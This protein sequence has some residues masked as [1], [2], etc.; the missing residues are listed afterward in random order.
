[1]SLPLKLSVT[2]IAFSGVFVIAFEGGKRR[3][4]FCVLDPG[5]IQQRQDGAKA[6]GALNIKG[7]GARLLTGAVV[8]SEVGQS[9]KHVLKNV[10]KVEKFVLDVVRNSLENELVFPFVFLL[11]FSLR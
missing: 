5:S 3:L 6:G 8:E 1:M 9:D 2:S 10:G 4:H 11:S 7:A